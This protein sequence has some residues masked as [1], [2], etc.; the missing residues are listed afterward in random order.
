[1]IVLDIGVFLLVI[2]ITFITGWVIGLIG[3]KQKKSKNI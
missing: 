1:M 2:F 3:R